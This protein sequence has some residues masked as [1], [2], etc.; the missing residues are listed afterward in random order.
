MVTDKA[1]IK[2][3]DRRMLATE[4]RDLMEA[5]PADWDIDELKVKPY[6][7]PIVAWNHRYAEWK[8]LQ[9]FEEL[10]PGRYAL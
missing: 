5:P 9:R 8:W 10:L 4:R 2:E 3:V 7:Q 6:P 1:A